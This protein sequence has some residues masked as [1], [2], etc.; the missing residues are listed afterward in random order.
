MTTGF[1]VEGPGVVLCTVTVCDAPP[2]VTFT[3]FGRMVVVT[4]APATDA[5]AK[6]SAA[7][8][9]TRRP[10]DQKLFMVNPPR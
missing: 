3:G 5:I 1:V 2:A 6:S 8:T 4:W 9:E 10:A 7:I